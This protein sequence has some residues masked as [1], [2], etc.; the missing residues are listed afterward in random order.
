MTALAMI[1]AAAERHAA[2]VAI[3][4]AGGRGVTYGELL[5]RAR[6]AA[7]AI[8]AGA[9]VELEVAH[10]VDFLV[11][12]LAAWL[13]GAAFIPIDP[14]EPAWRRAAFRAA[15]AA[16]GV[17]V[18][19][20]PGSSTPV[21]PGDA[22]PGQELAYVIATPGAGG[23]P[24]LVLIG[25]RALPAVLDAQLDAFD[26]APGA[27]ALWLHDA[28][29][30]GWAPVLAAGATLVVPAAGVLGAPERLRGELAR[31]GITHVELPP[32][33]VAQLPPGDPPPGL[34]VVVLGGEP[35]PIEVLRSLARR[36]RVVVVYGPPEA[37]GCAS[38][39]VVDPERWTRPLIG[40][41]LPGVAFRVIDGELWIGG[42]GLALGYAGDPGA[43]ARAF[44]EQGGRRMVRTGD[45]VEPSDGGLAFAGRIDRQRTIGGVR[46]ELDE[47]EAVLR[48]APGVR[49]AAVTVATPVPGGRA[50]L[51]AFVDGELEP[52]ALRAWLRRAAP[53]QMVPSR[54]IPGALPR[55]PT[56]QIDHDALSRRELPVPAP[57]DGDPL[58]RA[59]AALWCDALGVA[60]VTGERFRDAGGDSLAR[61]TL[62]AATTARGLALDATALIA[63]PTFP[64]L[65]AAVRDA[66][67]ASFTVAD[68]EA[69]GLAARTARSERDR[70][71]VALAPGG[72][73]A[74]EAVPA[75][76]DA[77]YAPAIV[78]VR[79]A[80]AGDR[81]ELAP[82][83]AA[84]TDRR[85]GGP[86]GAVL[87]TGV[88][89][90]LGGALLRTWQSRDPRPLIA[91]VRAPDPEAARR[92]LAPEVAEATD[93][94]V[95]CG[96]LAQPYFGLARDAWRELAGRVAAVVHA[97]AH[98][99]LAA[100]WDAHA[101]ANVDG[102]AE[103]ARL[104][105]SRAG[106]AWHHVST[107]S[108]FAGTDRKTG[109]HREAATPVARAIAHGGYVQTKIAAEAIAR[110]SRGRSAPTTILRLGLLVGE[111][112]RADHQLA[113]TLRGLA[114]LGAIPAG[115][116]ELRLDLTPVGYAAAAVAALAIRAER[117][118]RDDTHH[119]ASAGDASFGQLVAGLRVA[120]AQL[121]ELPPAVWAERAR[122]R[123]ADPDVAMAYLSLGGR[124]G[125]AVSGAVPRGFDLFRATGADFAVERTTR[126]LA[127]L[128]V[129]A[130]ELDAGLLARLAAEAL[131]AEAA[132]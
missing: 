13:A 40:E 100:G 55:T 26:L 42:D 14:G 130:P 118:G 80:G 86:G 53:A 46:V 112:P 8:A 62:Q 67:A 12:C 101:A 31:R 64:E 87:V 28:S 54:V 104:V 109:V 2:R 126:L 131:R 75:R 66:R 24:K 25:H 92:R 36:V 15:L 105:G 60:A 125:V 77:A 19:G 82:G 120:G 3:E 116:E 121:V 71:A 9:I 5:G 103:I 95:I 84:A 17:P 34:R 43:T 69:R 70:F 124:L 16:H 128:G 39:V 96:E 45:R 74:H 110:A 113:M 50:R 122:G 127:E 57:V 58:E 11:G 132:R 102:T 61:L 23:A 107:L 72:F 91:L 48:R 73:V 49:E 33:L 32:A 89:G 115:A 79:D 78:L 119:V 108:V 22:M 106:I 47:I 18:A 44:V 63:D 99:D 123:L 97:A 65:V 56:G 51:V 93:V 6:H 29:V 117:A 4:D 30:V 129:V 98:I 37:A 94:E 41:P 88:T 35:C 68:C 83:P 114:R 76:A 59:L 111:A 27:R 21:V 81:G 52:A 38:L 90:R 7:G 85:P 20:A 1:V 10:T